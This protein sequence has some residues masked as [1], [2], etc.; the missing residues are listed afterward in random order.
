VADEDITF[1]D[2]IEWA[3]GQAEVERILAERN[4]ERPEYK[5]VPG[6]GFIRVVAYRKLARISYPYLQQ[7]SLVFVHGRIRARKWI[8][9]RGREVTTVEVLA[10]DITF[11]RKINREAGDAARDRYLEEQE[12]AV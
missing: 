11:L 1:I 5:P 2:K 10:R 4:G 8:D 9:K 12:Q 6:G 3:R 7:G